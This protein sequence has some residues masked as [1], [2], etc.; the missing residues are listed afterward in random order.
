MKSDAP[1]SVFTKQLTVPQLFFGLAQHEAFDR[2]L[3]A[4]PPNEKFSA[5]RATLTV[6]LYE[7]HCLWKAFGFEWSFTKDE[8][9]SVQLHCGAAALREPSIQPLT[10]SP[11]AMVRSRDSENAL[12]AAPAHHWAMSSF[13]QPAA[14]NPAC[15]DTES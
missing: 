15:W 12:L 8:K 1:A 4:K 7:S 9:Q 13:V 6:R 14:F 5:L 3:V 10:T 11:S 2:E